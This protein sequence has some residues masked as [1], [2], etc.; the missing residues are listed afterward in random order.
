MCCTIKDMSLH[1]QLSDIGKSDFTRNLSLQ[2]VFCFLSVLC[3]SLSSDE[4]FFTIGPW[5][6]LDAYCESIF[7]GFLLPHIQNLLEKQ[8]VRGPGHIEL[9][10]HYD[11]WSYMK[12]VGLNYWKRQSKFGRWHAQAIFVKKNTCMHGDSSLQPSVSQV[13][14]LPSQPCHPP[15]AKEN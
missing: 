4:W 1:K 3:F 5:S 7:C 14:G 11:T 2:I 9:N 6:I 12:Y 10:A 13:N 15:F 8:W